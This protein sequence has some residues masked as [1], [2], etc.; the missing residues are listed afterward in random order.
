MAASVLRPHVA[1]MHELRCLIMRCDERR[2]S[3]YLCGWW[4]PHSLQG[5]YGSPDSPRSTFQPQISLWLSTLSGTTTKAWRSLLTEDLRPLL[6]TLMGFKTSFEVTHHIC[7]IVFV[8]GLRGHRINTWSSNDT[9]WPK[10][11][12]PEDIKDARILTVSNMQQ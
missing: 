5:L 12:L 6:S 10:D 9:C 3:R 7:S 2:A 1:V 11:L 8:H 4:R